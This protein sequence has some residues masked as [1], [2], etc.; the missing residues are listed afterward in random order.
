MKN[1]IPL[2]H[3]S[4]ISSLLPAACVLFVLSG[5]GAHSPSLLKD[6]RS[7]HIA[8][9][10]NETAQYALEERLTRSMI[11]AFQRDGQLQVVNQSSADLR[12]EGVI[13][14]ARVTP[15]ARSDLDRAV[16]YNISVT[17]QVTVLDTGTGQPLLK[18]R[19][20]SAQGTFILTNEPTF[21]RSQDVTD[22]LSEQ[23]LSAL[24]EGW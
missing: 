19:P 13:T 17:L 2:P 5:C 9:F 16:G 14:E 8:V 10:K 21:D 22:N 6:Q 3:A 15:I 12:M 4:F 7:I 23:V 20:F 1:T 24:I 18:D 11:Q